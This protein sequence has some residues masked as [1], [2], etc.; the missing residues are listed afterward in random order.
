MSFKIAKFFII[1]LVVLSQLWYI[2]SLHFGGYEVHIVNRLPSNNSPLSFRVQSKND[3]LGTHKLLVGQD[4][5]FKFHLAVF[6]KTLFFGNFHWNGKNAT[7]DVFNVN[8][9][10]GYCDDS[11]GNRRQEYYLCTWEVK[12]DGF[13]YCQ[14]KLHAW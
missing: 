1:F 5:T 4:F 3:D 12:S 2:D 7:F 11:T 9:L 8:D 10:Q 6:G 13:Y 14:K